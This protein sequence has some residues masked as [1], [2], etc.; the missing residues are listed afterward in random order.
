MGE[1]TRGM[2]MK[3]QRDQ[4]GQAAARRS[5]H[6]AAPGGVSGK[7]RPAGGR[8]LALLRR[9]GKGQTLVEM[10]LA[11]PILMALIIG[12]ASIGMGAIV[13]EQLGEAAFAGDQAMATNE[14]VFDPGTTVQT[15]ICLKAQTA[16]TTILAAPAWSAANLGKIIY[17]A[18][19]DKAGVTTPIP[20][21]TGSFSCKA[22]S[23][24]LGPKS[25]VTF[26]L[27]YT[28]T[29]LPITLI[30]INMG[31]ITFVRQQSVLAF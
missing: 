22:L 21:S 26:T 31:S 9:G 2:A 18:S 7:A 13:Y 16:V 10:A 12:L 5:K 8:L 11:L 27:Q 25:N 23:T 14:G 4:D 15:D 29:W 28:Y 1:E 20:P 3:M 30:K 19:V 24:D 17:S 6:S